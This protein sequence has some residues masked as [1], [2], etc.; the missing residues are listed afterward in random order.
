M[1]LFIQWDALENAKAHA[2]GINAVSTPEIAGK[3]ASADDAEG[4]AVP[5][6]A[7]AHLGNLDQRLAKL[8]ETEM[9]NK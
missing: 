8:M 3:L 5:S 4:E 9:L 2:E 1:M 6:S 7:S